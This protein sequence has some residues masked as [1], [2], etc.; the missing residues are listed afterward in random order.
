MLV[1]AFKPAH[2]GGLA[3]VEDGRVSCSLESEKDSNL[4]HSYLTPTTVL[5]F[6]ERL[7]RLPDVVAL[8]GWQ[9]NGSPCW[10]GA[11]YEDPAAVQVREGRFFGQPVQYFSSSH[12]RSGRCQTG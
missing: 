10:I 5:E 11:G 8:S 4:R 6:A 12:V 1:V 3:V 9:D 7:G 2:D